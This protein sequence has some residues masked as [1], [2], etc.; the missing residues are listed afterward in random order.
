MFDLFFHGESVWGYGEEVLSKEFWT[1]ML[2]AFLAAHDIEKFSLAGFSMGGR[3]VF[4]TIEAMPDRVVQIFLLAPDGVK[5]NFWYNLATYPIA[6][7]KLFKSMILHPNYFFSIAHSIHKLGLVDKGLIRFAESQMKTEE[8]RSRVY[9]SWVV[10]RALQVDMQKVA[11][12]IQQH[13][14]PTHMTLGKYDK[15]ITV[16]NMNQL[17][18]YLPE[19][20]L[21]L[22]ETGHNGI[23]PQWQPT[24]DA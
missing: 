14:I 20:G 22:L 24:I 10:F 15:V 5:T 13:S 12:L 3:F 23:I 17:L 4:N 18:K 21:T 9:F 7:R 2:K 1:A 11:S 16:K 8:M 19:C 6:F